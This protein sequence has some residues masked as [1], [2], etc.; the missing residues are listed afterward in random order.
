M[1]HERDALAAALAEFVT[2]FDEACGSASIDM[3]PG[4]ALSDVLNG[5]AGTEIRR[6]VPLHHQRRLGAFFTSHELADELADPLRSARGRV[7]VADPCCGAGDLLLAATR[8]LQGPV[9]H[10]VASASFVG[11]DL[12][13]QFAQVARMRLA[14]LV[15]TL[16]LDVSAHFTAGDG[17][18]AP[19]IGDA[20]HVLLN[21]P[22]TAVPSHERCE[23]AQGNVNGAAHFLARVVVRFGPGTEVS[24]ILPDVLRSGTR[25]RKWREF[26]AE[27]LDFDTPEPKGR[28]DKWTDIDVLV[29]RGR[30][31]RTRQR[32]RQSPWVPRATGPTVGGR[33]DVSVG[34]LVDYR[35]PLEGPLVP[36]LVAKDFPT[37]GEIARVERTRRFSG[38]LHTGPLVVIPRTSRP[39]D[40]HRARAAVVTDPRGIAVENHL[41]VARPRRGGLAE[42]ERLLRRLQSQEVNDWLDR[43]IR[44]RHLTV[45]AMASIP[46]AD[47][48]EP[49]C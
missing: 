37:W 19:N 25:Y 5:Q 45:G 38:R 7:T 8:A 15:R 47:H 2:V 32:V 43:A 24:A 35:S 23:W 20:T 13:H 36:Y 33:F 1:T 18:V 42:C 14:L 28:F 9:R 11:I 34:P 4:S 16:G 17:M 39:G 27:H 10:G 12:V 3:G 40:P 21:P 41:L 49:V 44:C 22:F 26:M 46:W 29:L 30:T 6:L 31:R 48:E